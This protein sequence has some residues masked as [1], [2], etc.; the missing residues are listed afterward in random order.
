VDDE[1]RVNEVDLLVLSREIVLANPVTG[2]SVARIKQDAPRQSSG[3]SE[4]GNHIAETACGG[5]S[6]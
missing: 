5:G 4:A 1:G 2:E 3:V 6:P